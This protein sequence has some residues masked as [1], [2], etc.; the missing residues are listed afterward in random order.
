[1]KAIETR[2]NKRFFRS[3]LEARWAVYFDKLSVK[4]IY[5]PEGYELPNGERYLPDFYL[6]DH[7]IYVEVKPEPCFESRWLLFVQ[8]G[9]HKLVVLDGQPEI[10]N[11][12]MYEDWSRKAEDY[13]DVFII[14]RSG[15]YFPMFYGDI[16]ELFGDGDQY[17]DAVEAALS[18]RFEEYA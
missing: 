5:E 11:Y 7:G 3:R 4:W 15:K 8:G 6:P 14:S 18:A 17:D 12:R 2:Y 13:Q 10:R 1:M 9:A 16:G